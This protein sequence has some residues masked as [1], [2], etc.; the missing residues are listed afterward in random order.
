MFN[1]ILPKIKNDEELPE[2]DSDS[3]NIPDENLNAII[4]ENF[5]KKKVNNKK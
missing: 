2:Y 1:N 5:S 4:V 3:D